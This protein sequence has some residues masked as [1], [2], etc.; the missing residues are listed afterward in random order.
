MKVYTVDHWEE[1]WDELL[2][3]VED[4]EHI[5]ISNGDNIAVMI[6][7]DDELLRIYTEHDEAS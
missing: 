5:G 6:P 1:H 2:S 7:A 4:G 3:R